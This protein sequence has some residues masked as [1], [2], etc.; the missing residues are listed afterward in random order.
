MYNSA[1]AYSD[2]VKS[3]SD[4]KGLKNIFLA[5]GILRCGFQY[6]YSDYYVILPE[7]SHGLQEENMFILAEEKDIDKLGFTDTLYE[8][9]SVEPEKEVR[10]YIRGAK[11]NEYLRKR[12][13][14][15]HS[16]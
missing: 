5:D 10:L 13:Y 9:I 8:I 7:D 12:G 4:E 6:V 14:E 2:I 11:M 3:V 16:R 1:Y 15:T